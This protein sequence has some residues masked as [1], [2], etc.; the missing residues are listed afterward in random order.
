M[1]ITAAAE[2]GPPAEHTSMDLS[3]P[4]RFGLEPKRYED[5]R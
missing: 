4:A 1:A 3:M 5:A 2:A